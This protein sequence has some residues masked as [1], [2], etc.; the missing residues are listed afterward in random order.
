M[1]P[2]L[3]SANSVPRHLSESRVA[4]LT[5]GSLVLKGSN[6]TTNT[7]KIAIGFSSDCLVGNKRPLIEGR[8]EAV[9]PQERSNGCR[10]LPAK[11]INAS[12]GSQT[13][14]GLFQDWVGVRILLSCAQLLN[15][16]LPPHCRELPVRSVQILRIS[17]CAVSRLTRSPRTPKQLQLLLRQP[18]RN[19]AGKSRPTATIFYPDTLLSGSRARAKT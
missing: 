15:L 7:T 19:T 14:L 18:M 13:L 2:S 8:K 5:R 3:L 4:P 17:L 10:S 9:A 16:W 12:H 11:R 6:V 1:P